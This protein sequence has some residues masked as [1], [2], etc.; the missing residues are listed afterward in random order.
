MFCFEVFFPNKWTTSF[1]SGSIEV[2]MSLVSPVYLWAINIFLGDWSVHV[3]ILWYV[4]MICIMYI[5]I[6]VYTR[7]Y[8]YVYMY[9]YFHILYIYIYIYIHTY[10]YWIT[11]DIKPRFKWSVQ[12]TSVQDAKTDWPQE[13]CRCFTFC[14]WKKS[15]DHQLR[16]VVHPVIYRLFFTSQVVVRDF[17]TIDSMD[18]YVS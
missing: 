8:V 16:L 4:Y 9:I 13:S 12:F 11:P 3:D 6:Y 14:W 15:G 17:W 2:W 5:Y 1:S 10:I 7:M 18:F